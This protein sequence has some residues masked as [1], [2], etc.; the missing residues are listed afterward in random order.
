ME[1]TPVEPTSGLP[2]VEP[3]PPAI[4]PWEDP[5]RP[6]PGALIDTVRLMI[7]S[8]RAA[9]ERVPVRGDVLR[10]VIFALLLGWVGLFFTAVY[11]LTLGSMVRSMMP[12]AA[13]QDAAAARWIYIAMIPLGPLYVAV[14]LLLSSAILHVSLLLVGGAKNGFV[15]TLRALCYTQSAS[16]ALVL[17]FCGSLLGTIGI[18]VLEVIGLSVLH[19]ITL[20]KA[21]LAVLVPV[22]LCCICV[23]ICFAMFGAAMMAGLKG[24]T[25]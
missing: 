25:P 23:S 17:P 22:A 1:E 18:L 24:L 20:G 9:F 8:P 10:P 13:G 5:T 19:R 2:P 16:I 4:I 11:E 14:G 6:W 12:A 7:T 3:P 21:V 15:A